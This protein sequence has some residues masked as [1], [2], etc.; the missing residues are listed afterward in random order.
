MLRYIRRMVYKLG[1][2]PKPG[3]I[4]Y[5]PSKDAELAGQ[6]A[7]AAFEEAYE[8]AMGL[9]SFKPM[10]IRNVEGFDGYSYPPAN[11]EYYSRAD[12]IRE[13]FG[14]SDYDA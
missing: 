4:F 5:S 2:R 7:L 1:F 14:G 11:G 8:K 13:G 6:E 12:D 10:G 9:N 3:S